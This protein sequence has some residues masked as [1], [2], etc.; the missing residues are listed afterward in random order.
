MMWPIEVF[1]TFWFVCLASF[2]LFWTYQILFWVIWNDIYVLQVYDEDVHNIVL[3]SRCEK[4]RK[5][6]EYELDGIK[7]TDLTTNDV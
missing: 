4:R 6:L 1:V 7:T 5:I 2:A 3:E